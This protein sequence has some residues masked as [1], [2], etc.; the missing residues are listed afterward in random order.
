MNKLSLIILATPLIVMAQ[1]PDFQERSNTVREAQEQAT[2][3]Y[4]NLYVVP[5]PSAPSLWS[6]T[7][8]NKQ[9][10][11]DTPDIKWDEFVTDTDKQ[12]PKASQSTQDMLDNYN[13]SDSSGNT[14]STNY[15]YQEHK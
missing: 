6:T 2:Q 9:L 4:K 5:A 7:C 10:D 1:T 12:M 3:F 14:G 11:C 8:I 15:G 13:P